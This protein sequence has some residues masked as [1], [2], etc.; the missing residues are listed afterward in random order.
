MKYFIA[1]QNKN[2]KKPLISIQKLFILQD[3]IAV[4]GDWKGK[5]SMA[6][7]QRNA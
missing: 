6:K 3:L 4:A 1:L 2:K 5:N 7:I